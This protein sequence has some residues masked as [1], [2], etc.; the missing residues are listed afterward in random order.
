MTQGDNRVFL[1][2]NLEGYKINDCPL[3][4][5][6]AYLFYL[7]KKYI[8]RHVLF[9]AFILSIYAYGETMLATLCAVSVL[10]SFVSH[11]AYA[12]KVQEK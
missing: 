3:P 7:I 2:K 6:M 5:V 8:D 1:C 12:T 11:L 10:I 4:Q 9:A